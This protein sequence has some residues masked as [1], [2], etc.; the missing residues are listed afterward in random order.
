MGMTI[1]EKILARNSSQEIVCPGQ[2]VEARVDVVMLHDIGTPGIQRP[3]RE[4]GTGK[5]ASHVRCVI[6]PDHYVP[7]PTVQAAENLKL[8]R[9]WAETMGVEYY[10]EPGRGGISHQ[11]MI[12]Q[13]HCLPGQIIVAPDSHATTYGACGALGTGLGVTDTAIAFGTGQLWFQ[14]PETVK[15]ELTGELGPY[16]SAKDIALYLLSLFGEDKLIYKAIE[17]AGPAADR[18][19][20]DSHAC[21]ANMALEMGVKTCLF[22]PGEETLARLRQLRQRVPDPVRPDADA[23]YESI[24][25]ID[26]SL[27]PPMVATPHSPSNGKQV[28]EVAGIHVHQAFLGSCTNGRVEDLRV[29]ARLMKG[30]SVHSGTRMIVTPA[31][32]ETYKQAIEEGLIRIFLDAGALVTNPGCGVCIGGHLGLIAKDE[33]CISASN[34]NFMGRMGSRQ[35]QIY[36][37]SPAV[38]AA[39]ALAGEIADP[40]LLKENC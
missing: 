35:G 8:T 39:S 10:Y 37:A 7:A 32:Q 9:E 31:S 4:L 30:H 16:V 2:I 38:V 11:I 34:R 27:I 17:I 19:T 15:I 14:V 26:V 12:E 3:F 20:F 36:L 28:S 22:I 29:A 23:H 25:S 24:V 5:I 33:V 6:V 40:R 13:G 18:L 1:V 21:I